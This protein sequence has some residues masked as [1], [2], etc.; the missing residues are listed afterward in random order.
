LGQKAWPVTLEV[1]IVQVKHYT[2]TFPQGARGQ[3]HM[4]SAAYR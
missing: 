1:S 2:R 4:A 3:P